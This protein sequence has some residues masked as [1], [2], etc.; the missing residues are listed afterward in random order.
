MAV[1]AKFQ[2][3]VAEAGRV[4][5]Y[6]VYGGSPEN[7]EF[8]AATPGGEINLQILNPKAMAEFQAGVE[9]YVTFERAP[10]AS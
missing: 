5:M 6:P 4:Q 7:D 8:F 3:T 1:V 9:Y 10:K 2:A